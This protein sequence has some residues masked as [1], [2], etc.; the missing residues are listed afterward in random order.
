[1]PRPKGSKNQKAESKSTETQASTDNTVF[2]LNNKYEFVARMGQDTVDTWLNE[3]ETKGKYAGNVL[4]VLSKVKE[5]VVAE[6]SKALRAAQALLMGG[7]KKEDICAL[8][9]LNASDLPDAEKMEVAELPTNWMEENRVTVLRKYANLVLPTEDTSAW[10]K[11]ACKAA[12]QKTTQTQVAMPDT[13]VST[14]AEEYETVVA[15]TDTPTPEAP[16]E[17]LPWSEDEEA[18]TVPSN[19]PIEALT[20]PPLSPNIFIP[21]PLVPPPAGPAPLA[22]QAPRPLAPPPIGAPRPAPIVPSPFKS[23]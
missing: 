10:S 18:P 19:I 21:P 6:Q 13:T 14:S 8:L 7:W 23:R 11:D 1:M 17:D 5:V 22:P 4:L 3:E 9:G 15:A 12:I 2:I 20:P 16:A